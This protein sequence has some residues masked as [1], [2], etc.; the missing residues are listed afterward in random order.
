MESP[1][2]STTNNNLEKDT[3]YYLITLE[4]SNGEHQQIRVFK[5]SDPAEIAFNFCKENNL[6]F[7]SMKYIKK[8]IQKI[9]EQFDEPNHKLFFLDN[10][11]SSIQEVDEENLVSETT[12]LD[13]DAVKDKNGKKNRF[14]F[15]LKDK[16]NNKKEKQN[17]DN[18]EAD[19]F[20]EKHSEQAIGNNFMFNRDIKEKSKLNNFNK[21]ELNKKNKDIIKQENNTNIKTNLFKEK[22]N[23]MNNMNFNKNKIF[24]NENLKIPENNN[25]L[26]TKNNNIKEEQDN[27][28]NIIN[29]SKN[30]NNKALKPE[31]FY[32]ND[33]SLK[34]KNANENNNTIKKEKQI[35]NINLKD[36][37]KLK[38]YAKLDINSNENNENKN[39]ENNPEII[40]KHDFN[41][42][43][44][45]KNNLIDKTNI[46]KKN[47]DNIMKNLIQKIYNNNPPKKNPN[48]DK[49][50]KTNE[51]TNE[52]ILKKYIMN[53]NNKQKTKINNKKEENTKMTIK[54][55]SRVNLP[56][57]QIKNRIKVLSNDIEKFKYERL[58]TETR[59]EKININ[60]NKISP[61]K[62]NLYISTKETQNPNIIY[63]LNNNNNIKNVIQTNKE[64]FENLL[65]NIFTNNYIKSNTHRIMNNCESQIQEKNIPKNKIIKNKVITRRRGNKNSL[66]DNLD[67]NKYSF[68]L[69]KSNNTNRNKLEKCENTG[70]KS[71]SRSRK[72]YAM[73]NGLNKIFN[74]LISDRNDNN[75]LNTDYIINKRCRIINNKNKKKMSMNLSRYFNNNKISKKAKKH[76]LEIQS[77]NFNSVYESDK[78]KDNIIYQRHIKSK[79]QINNKSNLLYLLN[80]KINKNHT[81]TAQNNS[82]INH[83]NSNIK[84]TRVLNTL[85]SYK[86][87]KKIGKF[88]RH[89]SNTFNNSSNQKVRKNSDLNNIN[90]SYSL[91]FNNDKFNIN[92]DR[93]LKVLDQ[94]YTINNT[95]NITNNN[96]LLGNFG[97]N[98]YV[99]NEKY[100]TD[101]KINILIKKIYKF[102]DKDN[103][104]FIILNLKQKYKDIFI[105]NN[106]LLNREQEK[107]LEKMFKILFE[108]HKK[109]NNFELDE[110]KIIINENFFIKYI[111]YIYNIKL[112]TNEKNIFLSIDN[113]IKNNI[114]KKRI[115][116]YKIK[117]RNLFNKLEKKRKF[118][119]LNNSKNIVNNSTNYNE[120]NPL[121]TDINYNNNNY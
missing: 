87:Q 111:N 1:L 16:V 35:G 59:R 47:S 4:D 92:S 81:F 45:N 103:I 48:N 33:M 34:Q 116:S 66:S 76:S 70:S 96:S 43:I 107:L 5:N 106:L 9:I 80:S 12:L 7:K 114:V 41:N 118:M 60:N 65:S 39:K 97:N 85:N 10:S 73:K 84:N 119:T 2:Y 63:K 26:I 40:L 42:D 22:N 58:K 6:D 105:Q 99:G 27:K 74:N 90:S 115:I 15:D 30:Y 72:K 121:F 109:K 28:N 20:K 79:N 104:G 86:T 38:N 89:D 61:K 52:N 8:N 83:Y 117:Q 98:H 19:K 56:Q 21:N 68:D 100:Y 29:K 11:Y 55:N 46:N 108:I 36:N 95:I 37:K 13:N 120:N 64:I 25:E 53:L 44:H 110:N 113:D 23:F 17:L 3:Q 101:D 18:K 51:I 77:S 69:L 94:Y 82:S 54:N 32:N 88:K 24:I 102:F 67:N 57:K 75:I 31:K 14:N 62:S 91:L 50:I 78:E 71:R 49:T 112:N 93:S